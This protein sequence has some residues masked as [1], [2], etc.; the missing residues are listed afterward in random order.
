MNDLAICTNA[1][2]KMY[3][4]FCAINDLNLNVRTGSIYSLIG[5]NGAGKTTAIKVLVGLLRPTGGSAAVLGMDVLRHQI[6]IKQ[7]TAYVSERKALFEAMTG[8]DL[9]RFS[10]I[11]FSTWSDVAA[12]SY[13]RRLEIQMDRP[14]R[15]L[16]VGSKSKICLLL[17]L[18]QMADLLVLDEP[19]EGLDPVIRDEFHKI[20][21]EDH[22]AAGRTVFLSTQHL[23]EI[24]GIADWIGIMDGGKLLLQ[25]RLDDIRSNFRRLTLSGK[26][27]TVRDSRVISLSGD[28][29]SVV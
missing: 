18:A 28:R 21:I 6:S 3:S 14:F 2:T 7:R 12:K 25:T 13:V 26:L 9:I 11:Y 5:R 1:L 4:G 10:Q 24:E 27:P 19:S 17:A 15:Q 23:D 16:S 29:K 8:N 20:L 22:V